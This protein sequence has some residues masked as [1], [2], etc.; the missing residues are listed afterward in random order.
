MKYKALRLTS[1]SLSFLLLFLYNPIKALADDH[2]DTPEEASVIIQ[3]TSMLGEIEPGDD[4][5]YFQ[6]SVTDYGYYYMY[7][8]GNLDTYGKLYNENLNL[9][10]SDDDD[11]HGDNFKIGRWFQ[12]GT[13]Y[14]LVYTSWVSEIGSYELY[15]DGPSAHNNPLDDHG[16]T[17]YAST[18]LFQGSTVTG[19][20]NPDDDLDYFQFSVTDYGYYYIYTGGNLDTYGK[21]Y[22]ENLSQIESDDDDGHSDNFRIVRWLQPGTYYIMLY[23]YWSDTGSYAL[24]LDGPS[25]HNNPFDDHGD[26]IYAATV[27]YQGTPP[28]PGQ[29]NPG[30]DLDYFKFTVA[31]QAWYYIYTGGNLDTYGKLYDENLNQIESDS[32][33]GHGDNFKILRWLQPGSYYV[34]VTSYWSNVGSYTLY[35]DGPSAHNDPFD[36]HADTHYAATLTYSTNQV[37]GYINLTDDLDFF[38][39][40]VQETD[41]YTIQTTGTLDTYGQL[42]DESLNQIASDYD[43]GDDDNFLMTISLEAG[44]YYVVVKSE[45]STGGYSLEIDGPAPI[46]KNLNVYFFR[47]WYR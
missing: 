1:I 23:T 27:L 45:S 12:P 17:I 31:D 42:L 40:F 43:D 36:D 34:L 9:I 33:D 21:L 41:E 44:T 37:A 28:M 7:T 32:S 47:K 3:G 10:E 39:F 11:G 13:Y 35:L 2:G 15:L 46:M 16:D 30:D 22:D 26:T 14:I 4:L 5:D 24:Y 6:F 25:A 8:G 29:I 20:I 38:E 18:S 19:Q